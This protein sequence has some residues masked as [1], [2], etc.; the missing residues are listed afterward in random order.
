MP[1]RA[2]ADRLLAVSS[3]DARP[4]VLVA[5]NDEDN[6]LML[7]FLLEMKG[8]RVVEARDGQ[9]AIEVAQTERPGLVLTDLHMPRLNGFEI[10]RYLRLHP[11]LRKVP[12]VV[13]SGHDPT[14]HRKL[15]LAAGCTEYL[16]KPID[17]DRLEKLL[18][19]LLPLA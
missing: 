12:I 11:Q 3:A 4:T 19:D 13:V 5:E 1:P 18:G 8:Y 17:F 15:A 7:R 10:T 14:Q 9:E 6:R 16:V 2:G